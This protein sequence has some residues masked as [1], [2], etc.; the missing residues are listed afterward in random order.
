MA[1]CRTEGIEHFEAVLPLERDDL[2]TGS[3]NLFI[4]MERPPQMIDCRRAGHC[5][6]VEEYADFGLK[7]GTERLESPSMRV[8]LLLV[9]LF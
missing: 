5:A 4:D 3:G 7:N 2:S 9:L 1:N 6:Y 8:N